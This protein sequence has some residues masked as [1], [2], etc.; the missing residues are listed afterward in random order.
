MAFLKKALTEQKLVKQ[1][2]LLSCDSWALLAYILVL[3]HHLMSNG[4]I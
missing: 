3:L 2:A 1:S 4:S